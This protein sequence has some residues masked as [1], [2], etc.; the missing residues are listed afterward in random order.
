[1]NKKKL[2]GIIVA[3]VVVIII[4]MVVVIPSL[5]PTPEP[6]DFR[7]S[8]LH[9]S[10]AEAEPGETVTVTVKVQNVGEQKG[11]HELELII[12]GLVEHSESV[13]LDGGQSTT[14]TF[15]V[16]KET[17]KSYSVEVAGLSKSFE[18]VAP[19]EFVASNLNVSPEEVEPGETVT[20]TVEVQNVGE[21]EGTHELELK[22]DGIVEETKGVTLDGG[23]SSTVSFTVTKDVGKVYHVAIGG[24]AASFEVRIDWKAIGKPYQAADGLTVTLHTFDVVEKPGS[25][26]YQITY[27]LANNTDSAID[28]GQFKLY[29][30]DELG[31]YPQYGFF[32]RV[33]P[34]DELTRSHTFEEE[35]HITF[36]VLAYHHD[37]FGAASPPAGA[38]Q[39]R[40]EY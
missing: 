21:Q 20:V 7:T 40:V 2:T 26:R 10:P 33:F 32:G 38:L 19:A 24:L 28:E 25:Y 36:G 8:N 34:G 23:E 31:G 30:K 35:K 4:V 1:M 39:W 9:V 14:I 16:Q 13:T 18:V 11:T 37:Q 15:T 22:V 12:D 3:C 29:Y 27:T 5:A 6:A 17:R